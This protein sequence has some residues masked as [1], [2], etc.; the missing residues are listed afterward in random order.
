MDLQP[1]WRSISSALGDISRYALLGIHVLLVDCYQSR[2][3][4]RCNSRRVYW[5]NI[6]S[7]IRKAISRRKTVSAIFPMPASVND[8]AAADYKTHCYCWVR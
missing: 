1:I 8:W 4:W 7:G 2:A 6:F 5:P 3:N